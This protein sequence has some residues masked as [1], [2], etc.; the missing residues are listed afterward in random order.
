[1]SCLGC[2]HG[3]LYRAVLCKLL[4]KELTNEKKEKLS[5]DPE[6]L[7]DRRSYIFVFYKT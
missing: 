1:M 7:T 4:Y 2:C 5:G 3:C 6:I